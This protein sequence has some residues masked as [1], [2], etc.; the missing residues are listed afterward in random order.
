MVKHIAFLGPGF[1]YDKLRILDHVLVPI[2]SVLRRQR[3][4]DY[5]KPESN[6][7]NIVS[8]R[9]ARTKL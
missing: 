8:Y 9:Q 5:C 4:E 3:Q 2:L 7:G 1:F 6:L